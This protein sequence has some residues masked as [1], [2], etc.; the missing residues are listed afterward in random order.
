[1]N[2]NKFTRLIASLVLGSILPACA[3]KK[4]NPVPPA[5]SLPVWMGTVRMVNTPE[6]FALIET[7]LPISPGQTF[8]A[9]S[10]HLETSTL[11]TTAL[12]NHPFLIA[13][14]VDGSPSPGDRIS[15]LQ[16]PNEGNSSNK[17]Q[18]R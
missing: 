5:P 13:D 10:E 14:I 4:P 18:E 6:Q 17:T 15:I 11:R 16:P 8:L 9:V 1:M 12:R 3:W 2:Q 7:T